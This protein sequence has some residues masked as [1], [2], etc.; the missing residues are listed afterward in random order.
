MNISKMAV[1]S[2]SLL[3]P[4]T[5][6]GGRPRNQ[7][8]QQ[9]LLHPSLAKQGLKLPSPLLK[10]VSPGDLKAEGP[11]DLEI[12]ILLS[13]GLDGGRASFLLRQVY[14]DRDV[15]EDPAFEAH[16]MDRRLPGVSTDTIAS[17]ILDAERH[18]RR[19]GASMDFPAYGMFFFGCMV[20]IGDPST[21][22]IKD[23]AK[24]LKL[25]KAQFKI[26]DVA[27]ARRKK[28]YFRRALV[29]YALSQEPGWD[30]QSIVTQLDHMG[31]EPLLGA[32]SE[33]HPSVPCA[34]II[35]EVS[36]LIRSYREM[37]IFPRPEKPD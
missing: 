29:L 5:R 24:W 16:P 1:R 31:F 22:V 32:R 18:K 33:T 11:T 8:G 13:F 35:F 15:T 10:F 37:P 6:D 26:L 3:R 20:R 23:F 9:F 30:K 19:T 34:K 25:Q 21:R 36:K 4:G 27:R 28:G 12:F 14:S 7:A 17:E 2:T